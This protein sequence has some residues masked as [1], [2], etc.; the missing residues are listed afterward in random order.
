MPARTSAVPPAPRAEGPI[1]II[2]HVADPA[3]SAIARAPDVRAALESLLDIV[4]HNAPTANIDLVQRAGALAVEAHGTDNRKSGEP[5]VL[6]PI[7]V[8]AILARMQL[9]P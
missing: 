8:A 5:Y 6:H 9:D 3:D 7:E 2:E 4:R 1:S